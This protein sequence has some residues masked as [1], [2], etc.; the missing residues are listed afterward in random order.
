MFI[1]KSRNRMEIPSSSFTSF[2]RNIWV[3]DKV[4]ETG[5]LCDSQQRRHLYEELLTAF[6]GAEAL[7]NSRPL[8]YQSVHPQDDVPITPN[9]FLHGQVGGMF[10][11]DSVDATPFNPR[12]RWRRIQEI[13]RHF[14]KRGMQE[15]LP[16]LQVRQKWFSLSR[17]LQEDDVVVVVSPDSPRGCWPLGRIVKTYPGPDGFVRV[18]DVRVGKTVLKRPVTRICPLERGSDGDSLESW[19]CRLSVEGLVFQTLNLTLIRELEFGYRTMLQRLDFSKWICWRW[20][21]DAGRCFK[22]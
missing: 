10:A 8:T 5:N 18:V 20:N 1:G 9:H 16:S 7:I 11:P 15:W 3:H 6:T 21:L 22:D 17:N 12:R 19:V 4:C 2:W 13:I 14:W